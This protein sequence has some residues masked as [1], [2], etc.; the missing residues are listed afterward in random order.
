MIPVIHLLVVLSLCIA[1]PTFSMDDGRELNRLWLAN[2]PPN[3]K[4]EI[5]DDDQEWVRPGCVDNISPFSE[6]VV[7]YRGGSE[8][9]VDTDGSFCDLLFRKDANSSTC[10]ALIKRSACDGYHDLRSYDV[11]P[12]CWKGIN[13][14]SDSSDN[15][16]WSHNTISSYKCSMRLL[17]YDEVRCLID[18]IKREKIYLCHQAVN[19]TFG[20][21]LP[22]ERI[23]YLRAKAHKNEWQW[24]RLLLLGHKD[25]ES[26]F[27]LLPKDLIRSLT[28]Y[29]FNA[30]VQELEAHTHLDDP[31]DLQ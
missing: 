4:N 30:H 16:F 25:S 2:Y 29:T 15:I 17:T 3:P 28:Q 8:G 12:Y 18:F 13:G 31:L 5:L 10:Y 1:L 20:N 22:K 6:M 7:A 11:F 14:A 26:P 27:H 23:N 24:Q 19:F 9:T 21:L